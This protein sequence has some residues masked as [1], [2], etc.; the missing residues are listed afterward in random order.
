MQQAI[1]LKRLSAPLT[2]QQT[3]ELIQIIHA[4]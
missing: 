4:K 1:E 3:S 2:Q